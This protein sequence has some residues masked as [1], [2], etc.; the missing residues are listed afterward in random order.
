MS[1]VNTI[2][3][4]GRCSTSAAERPVE[5]PMVG[6]VKVCATSPARLAVNVHHPV[7]A[8]RNDRVAYPTDAG[9]PVGE[10]RR[11]LVRSCCVLPRLVRRTRLIFTTSGRLSPSKALAS[12]SIC[13]HLHPSMIRFQWC[14]KRSDLRSRGI[15]WLCPSALSCPG[16]CHCV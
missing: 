10:Q 2:I 1:Q 8:T 12:I 15:C 14:G 7:A 16:S 6:S 3:P 11:E 13:T 5:G 9:I 4:K